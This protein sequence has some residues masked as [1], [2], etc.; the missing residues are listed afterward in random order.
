VHPD[1]S[2]NAKIGLEVSHF[3]LDEQVILYPEMQVLFSMDTLGIAFGPKISSANMVSRSSSA[4]LTNTYRAGA[5]L[6]LAPFR[7]SSNVIM[8]GLVIDSSATHSIG[9]A[10]FISP[11]YGDARSF[12]VTTRAMF[13]FQY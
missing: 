13:H 5:E 10:D 7:T 3:S 9:Q 8:S 4:P 2:I 6:V 11:V 12:D 1:Y